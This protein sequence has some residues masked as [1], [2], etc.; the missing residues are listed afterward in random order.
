MSDSHY[1]A[2]LHVNKKIYLFIEIQNSNKKD[3]HKLIAKNV[4]VFWSV[5]GHVC[6]TKYCVFSK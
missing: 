6:N 4:H 2:L 1:E 5:Y 3:I